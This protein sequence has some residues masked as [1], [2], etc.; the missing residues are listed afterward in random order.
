METQSPLKVAPYHLSQ[1]I[2]EVVCVS[3]FV[4][5]LAETVESD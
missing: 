5:S 1:T 3:R 2:S 4:S